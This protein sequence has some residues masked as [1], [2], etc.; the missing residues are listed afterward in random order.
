MDVVGGAGVRT[1]LGC[2]KA[3]RRSLTSVER[4]SGHSRKGV[5]MDGHHGWRAEPSVEFN[6]SAHA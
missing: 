6:V 4:R 1:V 5:L 2:D 3:S